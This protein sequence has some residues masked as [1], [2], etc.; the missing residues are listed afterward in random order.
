MPA[1]SSA[2]GLLALLDE[3]ADELKRYALVNL[4]KVV[5]EYWYQISASIASVEALYEDEEFTQRE[6]AAVVASKVGRAAAAGCLPGAAAADQAAQASHAPTAC[7]HAQVFYHLGELDDAL[8]YALGAG[9]LFDVNDPSEY[10]QT[11]IGGAHG[12]GLRGAA[13]VGCCPGPVLRGRAPTMRA[14]GLPVAPPRAQPAAWT[15]TLSCA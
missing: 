7:A 12:P 13:C 6:L 4:D 3:P 2:A 1:S 11:L 8:T 9:Q 10:V 15:S 5:H 14:W